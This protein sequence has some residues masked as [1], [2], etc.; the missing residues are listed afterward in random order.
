M[1]RFRLLSLW[2]CSII[3][4]TG[5]DL[6]PEDPILTSSQGLVN[7]GIMSN[8]EVNAYRADN[9]EFVKRSY[10][11]SDGTFSFEDVEYEGALY[12]EVTTTSQTLAT[13]DSAA[14]CGTFQNG[15]KLP[16]EF[17][18]N[19][20]G[21]VD[22]G[23]IHY[24]NNVDFLLTAFVKPR[25]RHQEDDGTVVDFGEF[26]VTPLTHIAAQKVKKKRDEQ[27]SISEDD[28]DLAN[29]QV[30]E[31]FGLDGLDITRTIPPDVTDAD[32]MGSVTDK[33]KMYS[34]LNAAVATASELTTKSLIEV[35]DDLTNS[36]V[37]DGGIVGSAADDNV[38]TSLAYL[39]WLADGIATKVETDLSVN[40]NAVQQQLVEEAAANDALPDGELV[41]PSE[42]AGILVDRDGDG[43]GDEDEIQYGTDPDNPD[44][45]GDMLPDGWEVK[46][47]MQSLPAG[48]DFSY[49]FDPLLNDDSQNYD[50]D[51][52]G[53]TA[54]QEFKLT[55]DPTNPDTNGDGELNDGAE[56]FDNDMLSNSEEFNGVEAEIPFHGGTN[57]Y[58]P[59]TDG[60]GVSDGYEVYYDAT[61]PLD[62][63]DFYGMQ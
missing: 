24:Y 21:N 49:K 44:S 7:K 37:D 12:V 50:G 61:D 10:T 53:L 29:A 38:D 39:F 22:F 14:G 63:D 15:L 51:G 4:L 6:L 54:H 32:K 17:D 36:F 34:T 9:L 2:I 30:A 46:Y 3:F 20:D 62:P 11:Q 48:W 19:L 58:N 55:T 42:N 52:D 60:D 1:E 23:D 56:D 25:I 57:P 13:C 5:C 16:G 45:D 35:I 31:L 40:M 59:D 8:A 43:L 47:S 27:G 28:V 18:A 33:E 41:T 26:A